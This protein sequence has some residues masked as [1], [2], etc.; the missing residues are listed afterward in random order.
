MNSTCILFIAI[1]KTDYILFTYF[2]KKPS[3]LS[4]NVFFHPTTLE[5][6]RMCYTFSFEQNEVNMD[7]CYKPTQPYAKRDYIPQ[8]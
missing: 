8:P 3:H 5:V 1:F 2:T 7:N 6:L 4:Y